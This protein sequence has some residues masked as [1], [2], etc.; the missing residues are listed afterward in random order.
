MHHNIISEGE[1]R[2]V[3]FHCCLGACRRSAASTRRRVRRRPKSRTGSLNK[4][5]DPIR[6]YLGELV[7]FARVGVICSFEHTQF[8]SRR[9]LRVPPK[10]L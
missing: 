3:G 1:E 2:S 10:G 7:L 6:Q 9:R 5:N 4:A 8:N